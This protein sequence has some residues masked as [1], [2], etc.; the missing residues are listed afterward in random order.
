MRNSETS[1][2]FA[3]LSSESDIRSYICLSDRKRLTDGAKFIRYSGCDCSVWYLSLEEGQQ[4][5][6]KQSDE[7]HVSF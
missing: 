5:A 3:L 2:L 1:C 7:G 4:S 6:W